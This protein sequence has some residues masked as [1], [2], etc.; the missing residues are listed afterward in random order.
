MKC[1]STFA[2]FD[3]I[4]RRYVLEGEKESGGDAR[5]GGG[6]LFALRRAALHASLPPQERSGS[7][8]A[9]RTCGIGSVCVGAHGTL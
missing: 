3:N 2:A 7:I 4:G 6:A 5:G 8:H 1:C 9:G